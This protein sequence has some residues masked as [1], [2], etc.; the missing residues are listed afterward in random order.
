MLGIAPYLVAF[1]AMLFAA[2]SALTLFTFVGHLDPPEVSP[3]S[4]PPVD[5]HVAA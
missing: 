1:S 3:A 4:T 2:L 5:E